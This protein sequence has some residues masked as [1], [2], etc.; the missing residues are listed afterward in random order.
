MI[1]PHVVLERWITIGARCR[2]GASAVLGGDPQ[3]LSYAGERSYLD[4]GDDNDIRELAVIQRS[5]K[6]EGHTTIGAH[7]MIMAQAHVAHDCVIGDHTIIASLTGLAGHVVVEDWATIGGVTGIHQ[8]VRIGAYSMVGGSSRLSQDVPPYMIVAG[9]PATV[10][11]LNAVGLRRHGF[12]PDLRRELKAAYR[13]LYRSGLN[14]SQALA[15]IKLQVGL[16]GPVTRLVQFIECSKRGICSQ[17][18][19]SLLDMDK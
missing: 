15:K 4:I 1:G 8:F 9:S 11:G 16:S 13:I 14:V 19:A 2:I 10:H 18:D 5:A 7:N 12:A 17:A 3:Y 6:P